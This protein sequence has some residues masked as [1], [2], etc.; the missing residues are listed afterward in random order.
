MLECGHQC[1]GSCP[2]CSQGRLHVPCRNKCNI[3]LVCGHICRESCNYTCGPCKSRCQRRCPDLNLVSTSTS[4]FYQ[5]MAVL[6]CIARLC[7]VFLTTMTT[8]YVK[9]ARPCSRK[10]HRDDDQ[11]QEQCI[12][13]CPEELCE[14]GHKCTKT[15]HFPMNCGL[16]SKTASITNQIKV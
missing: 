14:R 12:K 5:L 8:W 13:P 15:C 11:H 7:A 1:S 3:I 9:C 6:L 16:C 10:C 2:S 4:C